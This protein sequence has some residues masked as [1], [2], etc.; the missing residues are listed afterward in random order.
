MKAN[1]MKIKRQMDI[2]HIVNALKSGK[3]EAE[4]HDEWIARYDRRKTCPWWDNA[5]PDV[6]FASMMK[7]IKE[8]NVLE[9]KE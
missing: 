2:G 7:V 4:V 9:R 6:V 5:A 8:S 3:S 1:E